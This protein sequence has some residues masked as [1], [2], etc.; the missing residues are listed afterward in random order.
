MDKSDDN[1]TDDDGSVGKNVKVKA[2]PEEDT[3]K[4]RNNDFVVYFFSGQ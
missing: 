3:I 2:E 4:V 1:S